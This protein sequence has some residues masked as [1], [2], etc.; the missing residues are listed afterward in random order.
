[1]T[2]LRFFAALLVVSYHVSHYVPSMSFALDATAIA[3]VG[4]TF[5]FVLS[6]FVLTWSHRPGNGARVFYWRRLARLWPLYALACAVALAMLALR[7]RPVPDLAHVTAVL[8][9]VQSWNPDLDWHYGV[10]IPA[11]SLSAEAFF[12]AMFPL[13][14]RGVM[15][16]RARGPLSVVAYFIVLTPALLGF[17]PSLGAHYNI[18]SLYVAPYVRIGEFLAGMLLAGAM[19]R[20]WRPPFGVATAMILGVGSYVVVQAI[21]VTAVP[22]RTS[23]SNGMVTALLIIPIMALISTVAASDLAP[24]RRPLAHPALVRLGDWSYALYLLHC[25]F[26]L[27]LGAVSVGWTR[28]AAVLASAGVVVGVLLLAGVAYTAVERP[29][30]ARL[31][32]LVRARGSRGRH[33]EAR[34]PAPS[35]ATGHMPGTSSSFSRTAYMTASIRE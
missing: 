26:V 33:A 1:M 28:A 25:P 35:T 6:G 2:S 4:V 30:E 16:R 21:D 14:V 27:A 24:G 20:G 8:L 17:L 12:Y 31:R 19:R 18:S 15:S 22:G 13:L 32:P 3:N 9:M 29:I 7:H 34:R 10:N 5:F 11:W 23:L